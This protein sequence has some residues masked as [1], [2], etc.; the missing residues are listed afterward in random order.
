[1]SESF[2]DVCLSLRIHFSLLAFLK[3]GGP[4]AVKFLNKQQSIENLFSDNASEMDIC[5][6]RDWLESPDRE[7][8]IK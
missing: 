8:R 2:V 5:H 6:W 3:T 4:G 1:M 7:N